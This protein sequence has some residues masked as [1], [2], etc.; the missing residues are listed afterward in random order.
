[1]ALFQISEPG[2]A[3]AP[4]ERRHAVGIDLG[5]TNSLVACVRSGVAATLPDE[6]GRHLLPSVV[7]YRPQGEPVVGHEAM[8]VAHE[9][10][11]NTIAS[12]KRLMGRGVE[13]VRKLGQS[14]P[15]E[16]I[17]GDSAMP[18]LRTAAGERSPVEISADIL[19]SLKQRATQTL[20]M[21]I[22]D[23]VITVPAYFDD[24]QRQATK[25]AAR[26]AGLNVLRLLNEPTAAAIAYGLDRNPQGVYA[27]YDLGGGT[28]DISLLRLNR[29]VF[30]VMAT[31][32]DSA[33]GGDDMDHAIAEWIMVAAGIQDDAGHKQMR[34]LLRDARAAKE[35]LTGAERAPLRIDLGDGK[36][37]QGELTR[38]VLHVLIDPLIERTLAPCKRALRDAGIRASE[39]D[40]VVLVGGATRIPRV[41]A[42]VAQFF[43]REPLADIDPD[44]VVAIGA[45]L[46]ADVLIG[47]KRDEEMLLLDVIPLSL[48]IEI[49]G[50]MVE[51]IIP[52]NTTIPVAK[53]QDFTTYKDGQTALLVHVV[54]GERELVADC[55]S[56]AR[57]ELRGIPPMTAGAARIRVTY[58]IDADGL[59]S[60]SAREQ[61]TGVESNVTVKPSY[62]LTDNEIE[63]ML[64]DSIAHAHEDEAARQLREQQVE[65][66]RLLQAVRAALEADAALLDA[67]ER[68]GIEKG[69]AQLQAARGGH[70][71]AAIKRA[72][73]Q[74]D[75]AT[76]TFA[77]RR[78]DENVRKALAG[79]SLD[80]F[81]APPDKAPS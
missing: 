6:Q 28:F 31:G 38:E 72:I 36:S 40:G 56:L 67:T 21:E 42:K 4:H 19:K 11:L 45:A 57:F 65:A 50:G 34:R 30:E 29:G 18:R 78:M 59:L 46:Q 1:M 12:V 63:R 33:L 70:D 66:D 39:I 69:L 9:D 25:D 61:T 51:K 52:R 48:G 2:Q 60:V 77:Q 44:K 3:P 81:A 43:G 26:L 8:A 35:A 27:V 37:W 79:H 55:R 15:Y 14:L 49:M 10:P 54:Q 22:G 47:N 5:T 80:E 41:R 17:R 58:Q 16:F 76:Q 68:N 13:D 75:Q 71:T 23:A 73:K 74:L 24:A 53:S 7:R 20:G 64:R 32:G 62:G